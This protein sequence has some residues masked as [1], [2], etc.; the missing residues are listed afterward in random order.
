MERNFASLATDL[1]GMVRKTARLRDKG[2]LVVKTLKDF[3]STENGRLR[4]SLEGLAECCSAMED[5]NQ[6]KVSIHTLN[7]HDYH[8]SSHAHTIDRQDGG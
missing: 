6:L 4:K 1:G 8:P 7:P 3:A 5:C 2:D